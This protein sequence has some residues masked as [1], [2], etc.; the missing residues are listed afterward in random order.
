M[1]SKQ[2][3]IIT[4]TQQLK[5]KNIKIAC[6]IQNCASASLETT[7]H[8]YY[9]IIFIVCGLS[10]GKGGPSY[11]SCIG[12][13]VNRVHHH[14]PPPPLSHRTPTICIIYNFANHLLL[15][16]WR[17]SFSTKLHLSKKIC[18]VPVHISLKCLFLLLSENV[19]H[20]ICRQFLC[21]TTIRLCQI[22]VQ[23]IFTVSE[24]VLFSDYPLL[25]LFPC[26]Q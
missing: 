2:R 14:M 8:L 18:R 17:K 3:Y 23:V 20:K 4:W 26:A 9:C 1:I 21:E 7:F 15:Q 11:D 13:L 12:C 10:P 22:T 19:N 6:F 24:I 25:N 16:M 5:T